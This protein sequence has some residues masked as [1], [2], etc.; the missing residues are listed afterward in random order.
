MPRP[1]RYY[2]G[3]VTLEVMTRVL[4]AR[5]LLRPSAELNDLVLGVIGRV[6]AR[7]A[8]TVRLHELSFLST[9]YHA[10]FT[11]TCQA[12]AAAFMRDL[13]SALAKKVG[14]AC[15]WEAKIWG[16]RYSGTVLHESAQPVRQQ[17]IVEQGLPE[18]LF[19]SPAD[20]PCVNSI[21]AKARGNFELEGTWYDKTAMSKAGVPWH[22]PRRAEFGE[23]VTVPLHPWP[24]EQ[25]WTKTRRQR[26]AK[27]LI[28]Q[29]TQA[30]AT[31]REAEG[32]EV[33]GAD[34]MRAADPRSQTGSPQTGTGAPRVRG[35][36]QEVA[37][38]LAG[39]AEGMEARER[40]LD[41]AAETLD[42]TGW[43]DDFAVPGP[44]EV[45]LRRTAEQRAK[46]AANLAK[47]GH[48]AESDD[49]VPPA[50]YVPTF[51]ELEA[52]AA[53]ARRALKTFTRTRRMKR[54][55][56]ARNARVRLGA[57]R[58]RR[59]A[60]GPTA[61]AA[62]GACWPGQAH[63]GADL[64]GNVWSITAPRAQICRS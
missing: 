54:R 7:H 3:V 40:A 62:A 4:E 17:Y 5:R 39:Y 46:V 47:A 51:A 29:S 41:A 61:A 64:L 15:D 32:V 23:K 8:A 34:R 44:L 18:N 37:D 53:D 60:A 55:Q 11:A 25:R 6:L 24:F 27:A 22:S 45:A 38:Y 57:R 14:L 9:H 35:T 63:L 12:A 19:A 50:P 43:G 2:P 42:L 33:L 48:G 13:N 49:P 28:D 10:A 26:E 52:K 21:S 59:L 31:R 20:N 58:R 56:Q 1:C 16:Q 36:A 30:H